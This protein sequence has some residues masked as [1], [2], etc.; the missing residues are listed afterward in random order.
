MQRLI[1]QMAPGKS[2]KLTSINAF[3][4]GLR[5]A[6]VQVVPRVGGGCASIVPQRSMGALCAVSPDARS[7][8][9]QFGFKRLA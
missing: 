2:G 4:R 8:R 6:W 7:S 9:L 5:R 1:R 3:L